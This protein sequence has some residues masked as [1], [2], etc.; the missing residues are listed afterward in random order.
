[1]IGT[2]FVDRNKVKN[3]YKQGLISTSISVGMVWLFFMLLILSSQEILILSIVITLVCLLAI[4]LWMAKSGDGSFESTQI[5]I[6]NDRIIRKGKGLITVRIKF[7][8]VGRIFTHRNA[9]II[10]RKGIFPMISYFNDRHK[11]ISNMDILYIPSMIE[12][13]ESIKI[14]IKEK[15]C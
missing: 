7:N 9:L 6:E 14:Y 3:F 1:M 5:I 2:Y 10:V 8:E 4:G 13:F 12:N 11:F 15:R